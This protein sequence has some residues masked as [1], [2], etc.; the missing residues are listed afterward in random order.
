M[1]LEP[2]YKELAGRIKGANMAVMP[3][4]LARLANNEQARVLLAIPD[5]SAKGS[6]GRTLQV[7]EE[8][9]L[10]VGLAPAAVARH[11]Q[12][13]YEKGVVFPTKGGPQMA[14]SQIQLHDSSLNNPK[15]DVIGGSELF[16]LWSSVEEVPRKPSKGAVGTAQ[17][18]IVPKRQSIAGILD[19]QP[20]E[21]MEEILRSQDPLVLMHCCCKR[22]FHHRACGIP[23]ETCIA[24]GRTGQY[25]LDRGVGRKVSVE[26]ALS[27]IDRLNEY[28]LVNT[29][30]N[31]RE[32]SQ[33]VC[34]CHWCCCIAIKDSVPSRF[35]A[36]VDNTTDT[37]SCANCRLCVDKC[38]FGAIQKRLDEKSAQKV[39]HVDPEMCRGCGHCVITCP[40]SHLRMKLIRRP[41][42]I[43]EAL[44]IY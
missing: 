14:R 40:S 34:N 44:T 22:S 39:I 5:T 43:P 20:Y 9:A 23:T 36:Y 2:I 18:R 13:L 21:N 15:Y 33:L 6:Y 3:Q 10:R 28:P 42:H 32:V 4:I 17:F 41:E 30:I 11:I 31:Q 35:V 8:F 27:V 37:S 19:V 38:Q 26:E 25:N 12:E 1:E 16:D 24:L 7:S 29:T